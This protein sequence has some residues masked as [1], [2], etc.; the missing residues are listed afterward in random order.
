MIYLIGG[1]PRLGKS[2]IARELSFRTGMPWLSTD[3]LRSVLF[4]FTDPKKRL[5]L[6]PYGGV[7]DN[8]KVFVA[9]IKEIVKQ[10]R[11]EALS[12][13]PALASFIEHQVDV[14]EDSILEGVHLWPGHVAN[15]LRD[16]GLR[17]NIRV[18]FVTAN[19]SR[20]VLDG[21]KDNSSHYD[22]LRGARIKTLQAVAEFVV[23]FSREMSKDIARYKLPEIQRTLNFN[24][25]IK[26]AVAH[27][28]E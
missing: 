10:Q 20:V 25:D 6:F 5:K 16:N 12:M 21:L 7:T 17:K 24:K 2:T 23:E 3:V 19:D 4:E 26:H 22:W 27:L 8:D 18:V 14:R 13:R 9:P 1:A 28:L 15:L 11:Q